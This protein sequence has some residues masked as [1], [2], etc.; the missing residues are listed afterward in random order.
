MERKKAHPT[1]KELFIKKNSE[2]LWMRYIILSADSLL[3][4]VQNHLFNQEHIELKPEYNSTLLHTWS[5]E[6]SVYK[7]GF[8]AE[9]L[10]IL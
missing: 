6:E 5:V 2:N 3:M 10:T 9:M 4:S 1:V 7:M 8:G